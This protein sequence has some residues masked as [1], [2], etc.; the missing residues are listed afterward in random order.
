MSPR[1]S[2][3]ARST[4]PKVI[5][6]ARR[7]ARRCLP[8]GRVVPAIRGTPA[9]FH[10]GSSYGVPGLARRCSLFTGVSLY[11]RN[12]SSGIERSIR[13]WVLDLLLVN[14]ESLQSGPTGRFDFPRAVVTV[15][16]ASQ[17]GIYSKDDEGDSKNGHAWQRDSVKDHLRA[18][19]CA[20][21][22]FRFR[23]G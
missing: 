2:A 10:Q 19:P 6:A 20:Y 7:R 1:I 18:L 8:V 14:G 17:S 15:A 16:L 12:A 4:S 11:M 22:D 3:S 21:S 13:N 23:E 9:H 5:E